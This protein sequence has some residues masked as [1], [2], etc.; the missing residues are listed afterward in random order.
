[1]TL[2]VSLTP[3]LEQFVH[4]TVHSGRFQFVSEIVR[5]LHASRDIAALFPAQDSK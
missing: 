3:H 5:V 2:N 4:D 1:M